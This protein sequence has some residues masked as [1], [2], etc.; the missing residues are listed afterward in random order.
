MYR[1][2]F[3]LS[4]GLLFFSPTILAENNTAL[5]QEDAHRH[6]K[7][8]TVKFPSGDQLSITADLYFIDHSSPL[9][10][11]CH[12]AGYSRGEYTK[13]AHMFNDLGYNCMAI[14]QR[15]G[16]GVNGIENETA[17]L[18]KSKKLKQDYLAAEQDI[19]A[20][21]N[22]A[23]KKYKNIILVG[24]SYSASLVLKIASEHSKVNAVVSF[25]PGEYFGP[26]LNLKKSIKSLSI[27]SFITSSRDEFPGIKALSNELPKDKLHLF[28]PK[29]EGKHGSKAL[30]SSYDGHKE[31]WT[32]LLAFLKT[33]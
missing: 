20:A 2:L 33:L 11:L 27:P 32:A 16:N 15:S 21:I 10:I 29:K 9:M 22:Y 19:I 3:T 26:A 13:T 6:A 5:F 14:D 7:A 12:Q 8:E 23:S 25:S 30:W 28:Q 4:L 17:K 24:S 31:Y 18:A 1:F